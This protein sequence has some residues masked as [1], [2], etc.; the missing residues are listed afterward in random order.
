[1]LFVKRFSLFLFL[2]LCFSVE[3]QWVAKD[4]NWFLYESDFYSH[5]PKSDWI[6]IK[7][8]KKKENLFFGFLKKQAAVKEALNLGLNYSFNII[9][10]IAT[11]KKML[12]VTPHDW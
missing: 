2:G 10:K 7:D 6:S 11:R 12:L 4:G 9:K 8:K 5:V 3:G 1:M